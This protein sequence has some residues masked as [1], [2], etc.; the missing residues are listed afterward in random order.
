[1][2]LFYIILALTDNESKKS[3]GSAS[4]IVGGVT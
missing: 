1:M 3:E 4:L 2:N